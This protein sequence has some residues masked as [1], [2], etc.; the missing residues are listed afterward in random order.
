[1]LFTFMDAIMGRC[2]SQLLIA[3]G[4]ELQDTALA[5]ALSATSLIS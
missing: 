5:W 1:M 4:E 3:E 2:F